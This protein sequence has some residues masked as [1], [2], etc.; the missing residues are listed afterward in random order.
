MSLFRIPA[1]QD[2]VRTLKDPAGVSSRRTIYALIRLSDLPEFPMNPDP[3]MP[4]TGGDIL[5][6]I[7]ESAKSNDG[8]FHNKNR[9][10]TLS[11]KSAEFDNRAN[12]LLLEIPIESSDEESYGI[13][14]G[15]HTHRAIHNAVQKLQKQYPDESETLPYQYVRLEIMTGVEERIA[16]IARARNRSSQLQDWGLA[17]HSGKFQWLLDAV[18]D[19]SKFLRIR[20]NEIQPVP[21]MNV[22]QA[23]CAL[24]PQ[25]YPEDKPA[26]EAYANAGKCLSNFIADGDPWKFQRMAPICRD[27]LR[28]YDYIRFHWD[29][30]YGEPDDDGKRGRIGS[31]SEMEKRKR[32]RDPLLTFWFLE[33]NLLSEP[34]KK[35]GFPVEKGFAIPLLSAFR[36]LITQDADGNYKWMENPFAFFDRN[37]ISL[38]RFVM[39]ASKDAGGD[40]HRVGRDRNVYRS[41]YRIAQNAAFQLEIERLREAMRLNNRTD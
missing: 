20:E 2:F 17:G 36:V 16:E 6:T 8:E 21:I 41:L 30:K 40:A 25:L 29:E 23:L 4:K 1:F 24:N 19:Y 37:G 26:V 7:E 12:T 10:I 18:G 34:R 22:I 3:R 14:D 15:G 5:R 38:V 13:I 39:D 35:E 31:R 32:N 33:A 27:I 9:G 28:L 11:V